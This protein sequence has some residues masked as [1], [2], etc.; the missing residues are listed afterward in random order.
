MKTCANCDG[1]FGL[2]RQYWY[3]T[4]FCSKRCREKYLGKLARDKESIARWLGHFRPS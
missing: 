2:V 1:K 3:R 4:H